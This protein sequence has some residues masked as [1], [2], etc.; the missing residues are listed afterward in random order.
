[1]RTKTHTTPP[2]TIDE[3]LA[4]VSPDKRAALEQLRAT[5]RAVVPTAEECISYQMPAFRHEGRVLV[6]FAA[7]ANHCAF[8]PGGMVND[9]K[10]ELEAYETS[11]GT[12]RFQPERPLPAS[13][14]RKIVKARVAQNAARA[15]ESK[16]AKKVSGKRR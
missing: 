5:I 16:R 14:V 6:Y 1:M 13:L 10:D 7:A 12:I 4:R 2:A 3:Y 11:K 8:Y 15:S 9:F